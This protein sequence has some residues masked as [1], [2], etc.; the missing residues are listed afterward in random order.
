MCKTSP[1]LKG[2]ISTVLDV[3]IK[4]KAST[5]FTIYTTYTKQKNQKKKNDDIDI[6]IHDAYT[7]DGQQI[8]AIEI[9]IHRIYNPLI[10]ASHL[11]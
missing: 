4:Q 9:C 3:L 6:E 1:D 5:C 8:I 7:N 2:K 11:L 10:N